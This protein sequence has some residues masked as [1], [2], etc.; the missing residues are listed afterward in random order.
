MKFEGKSESILPISV[1]LFRLF[2]H[3]GIAFLL[4]SISLGIGILGYSYFEG[5]SFVDAL[6][7]A[8]MIVGGMGPVSQLKT[9]SGKI[10]ASFYAL[11]AA[12]IILT[13]AGVIF[14]PLIHRLL[15]RF[16]LTDTEDD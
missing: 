5:M 10:F 4:V 14:A 9:I 6:L 1:F 12:F 7:N 16:H 3:I 15:H 8:S 11:F 2:R 13:V